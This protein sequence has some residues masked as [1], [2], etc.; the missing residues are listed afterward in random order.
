MLVTDLPAKRKRYVVYDSTI[1]SLGVRVSPRGR[2]TFI[3]VG[4]F[5]GNKHPT[6][7]KLGVVGKL[8]IDQA[9][10]R[11]LKFDARPSDKFGS[12]AEQYFEH[13]KRQRR[14]EEV[15]RCIRRDLMTRWESKAIGSITKADVRE[16]VEAVKARGKLGAAQHVLSYAKRLFNYAVDRDLIEHSPCERVKA[17]AL[18]GER[19]PRQ[20]VLNDDEL[21]A[22]WRAAERCGQF[23]RLVQLILATG[24]RRSE[25]AFASPNEFDTANKLWT[26][27]P[28]RF[29][30]KTTHVVP[31]S[32]LALR[33]AT[34]VP[35]RVTGFSKSKK[36][37]DLFMLA[38]LRKRNPKAQF[39]PW[40]LHDLRRYAE[41]RIMPRHLSRTPAAWTLL[42]SVLASSSA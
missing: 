31:L 7:R 18:I 32:P 10:E 17:K 27:P 23:G 30:S 14:A 20:R 1:P 16:V 28:E 38:E 41:S 8:T 3:V 22:L 40:R 34:H 24:A 37:L 36:R 26:I 25:A 19:T 6:R 11:A 4:R 5:N 21:K 2:K 13:I 29:K 12:V 33:I 9:R 15:E 42:S 39:V 35:F